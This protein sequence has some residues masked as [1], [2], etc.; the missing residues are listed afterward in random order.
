L[1]ASGSRTEIWDYID[2]ALLRL[3]KVRRRKLAEGEAPGAFYDEFFNDNDVHIRSSGGDP[4]RRYL[5]EALRAAAWEHMP[6]GARVLDVGCGTGDNLRYILR[7]Q[8]S[9][10]GLEYAESTARAAQKILAGKAQ[11][12][13]G[14]ATDLRFEDRSFDLVVCIEVLEHIEDSEKACG[15]IA[16]VMKSGGALILSLPFRRWFPEYFRLMGHFRHYTRSD[17]EELLRRHGLT[18][19][20]HLPNF[21]RWSRFANYAYVLCR[22]YALMLRPFGVR[23][24]PSEARLPFASRALMDVLFSSIENIRMSERSLDYA[25]LETSTFVVARKV[26]AP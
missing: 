11:I 7:D 4:R 24:S 8:A 25:A 17:V 3:A 21:P 16:R 2:L 13:S 20:R 14:S 10:F 12:M 5:G 22:I 1:R 15:E 6:P 9:F 23:R 18:A 26:L 19:V